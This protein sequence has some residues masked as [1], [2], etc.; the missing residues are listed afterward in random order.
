MMTNRE[1]ILA[2]M[3]GRSPDRIPWIPRMLLWWL[4]QRNAGTLPEK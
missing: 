3:E 2:I 1:R 4:A